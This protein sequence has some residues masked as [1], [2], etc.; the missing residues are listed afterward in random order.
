V[1]PRIRDRN[2]EVIYAATLIL[3]TAYGVAISLIAHHLDAR[4]FTKPEM[5]SL[6]SWFALG[7]VSLSLPM[8]RAIRRLSAKTTLVAC[9]A[10]YAGTVSLFPFLGSYRSIAV[11]R[12]FDG[13][14]SVGIWVSCETILL[15]RADRDMKAYVTSLYAVSIALGYVLGPLAA[16]G[17][18]HVASIP[19]AF[20]VSGV[21][22]TAAT[23]LV[24][25]GLDRDVPE[26]APAVAASG[27][28]TALMELL[29][30]IKTSCFATFAYGYFQAS[31]VLFLPLYLVE[32][33]GVAREKTILIPFFFALGML[34]FSNVA[35]RLADRYGHLL[36]MRVLGTLGACMVVGFVV[37]PSYSLMAGAVFVAGATLA[38]ISPVSLALQG[39]VTAPRDYSRSNAIYNAFYAA[40]MLAGPKASSVLFARYGGTAMLLHLGALWSAFVAF[41]IVFSKDDPA[42]RA[43]GP[44]ALTLDQ[45]DASA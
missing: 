2:I 42:A 24:F 33:K 13:A 25:L 6:A 31:V 9:L 41:T 3:G 7:I 40:G 28:K 32:S 26:D 5:G 36:V 43:A 39:V 30:R 37:L 34:L 1:L 11:D 22:A 20:S 10:G 45:P 4:G 16:E 35:G 21:L 18:V 8:G 44:A 15:S 23:L 27:Q 12:F 14:F 38:S 17:I 19:R 29:L